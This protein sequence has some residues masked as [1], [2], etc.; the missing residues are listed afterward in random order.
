MD[1]R[2]VAKR[3]PWACILGRPY[4]VVMTYT[5]DFCIISL[6][7]LMV[8]VIF[9]LRQ[10]KVPSQRN[11][12]F[13]ALLLCGVVSLTFDVLAAV[14]NPYAYRFAP[15]LV[16]ALNILFLGS[17]QLSALLFLF[18]SMTLTD[19]YACNPKGQRR[20][21]CVPFCVSALALLITPFLGEYG[22][23]YLTK[24]NAYT[25]GALHLLLYAV[26]A[27]YLFA[28]FVMMLHHRRSLSRNKLL[29][30]VSFLAVTFAAMLVQMN[31]PQL[32]VNSM[33]NAFSLSLIYYVLEAPDGHVDAMT[34][35]YNR[36]A[37]SPLLQEFYAQKRR[38]TLLVFPLLSFEL[39]NHALG[40]RN[41]DRVLVD[42]AGYLKRTYPK[43]YCLRLAGTVFGVLTP[44]C[45]PVSAAQLWS[46]YGD[47]PRA[48]RADKLRVPLDIS[49]IGVNSEN[50]E[51]A[52]AFVAILEN[53]LA[54]VREEHLPAVLLADAEIK[55]RM[56]A[57]KA[58]EQALSRALDDDGLDVYYQPIH[59]CEGKL[60]ALEALVRLYDPEYGPLPTQE[61]VEL[62]EQNGNIGKL[63]RLVL[64]KVCRFIQ[65]N[66]AAAWGL[67]HIGV[68]LSAVQCMQPD[69]AD[70]MLRVCAQYDAPPSLLAFEI[71]ETAIGSID[72]LQLHMQCL[73]AQGFF[74][75]LDDFGKGYANISH[76]AHLPFHCVKI[77]KA[78]LW[79][80]QTDA[81]KRVLLE[82]LLSLLHTLELKSVCEGVETQAQ[83]SMLKAYGASMLQGYYF[84]K[85]LSPGALLAYVQKPGVRP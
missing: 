77:D 1:S 10:M 42:F 14:A 47:T 63:G 73:C 24:R 80:A 74:F 26:A 21:A 17:V 66:N 32:L 45:P 8:T 44:D 23:F 40:M 58:L 34:E 76:I 15:W 35:I 13:A 64:H 84:S 57:R 71:T 46:V 53:V 54:L 55:S 16:Y 52:E 3:A 72:M 69:L 60:V 27:F 78:L 4:E 33:G 67:D 79:E 83:L 9:Y 11:S 19:A 49:L 37:L 85:P 41:G 62:A 70:S 56:Q 59:N 2:A 43:A 50:V 25:H 48:F 7:F 20:L 38:C 22:V 12:F 30:I 51:N 75:L 29:C 28:S 36:A 31:H 65:E 6:A 18:Y 68:N 5:V 61:A 39:V 81:N 82:G